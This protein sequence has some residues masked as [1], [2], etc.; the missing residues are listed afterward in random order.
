MANVLNRALSKALLSRKIWCQKKY[1][2]LYCPCTCQTF[3]LNKPREKQRVQIPLI[4]VP[5]I[6]GN[7]SYYCNESKK[8]ETEKLTLF[9]RIKQ[10]YRDYWYVLV[11][12]HI[13][14]STMW[15]GG[16][17]Y[18]AKSGFDIVHILESWNVSDKVINPLRDSSMGYF[19]IA[20][21]CYKIATPARYT[22]T[23]GGTTLSINYLKKW[24]YIKPVPS[25]ERMKAI[26]QE[27]KK[28]LAEGLQE[29]KETFIESIQETKEGIKEKKD[30]LMESIQETK[31]GIKEK[32]D[33]IIESIHEKKEGL[34]DS[35]KKPEKK[36]SRKGKQ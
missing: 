20:Y 24:G 2:L 1:T 26:Y 34:K 19:A 31:E 35:L 8:S 4:N 29:K 15:F 30:N 23:L 9:Q 16:F 5:K 36:A 7:V 33:S 11:P 21:A 17:Y 18:M 28:S 6:H 32:K 12:V 22:V 13:V 10:M 14:T 27:K 25:T 3:A